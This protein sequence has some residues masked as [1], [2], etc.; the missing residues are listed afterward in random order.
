[1]LKMNPGR[2]EFLFDVELQLYLDPA[3]LADAFRSPV[4]SVVLGRSQDL[5]CVRKVEVVGLERACDG[6]VENTILPFE[7]RR[8]LPW[9]TTVL[10][11]TFV[12]CTPARHPVFA[13]YIVVRDRVYVGKTAPSASRRMLEI[14]DEP[15][16]VWWLDP[17]SK[18]DSGGKRLL[19][20]HEINPGEFQDV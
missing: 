19:W 10:M 13:S 5:A 8:C 7:F 11:P 4:F 16:K 20:F 6:Y 14:K 17:D 2:R 15:E 1:E 3:E 12:G 9:G 18:D